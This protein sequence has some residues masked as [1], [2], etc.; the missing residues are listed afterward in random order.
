MGYELVGKAWDVP[1][2]REYVQE[3]PRLGWCK[4]IC[5]HHTA[6]PALSHRPNGWRLQHM[7]NLKDYYQNHLG[8]SAGPHLFTDED[9]VFGMSSLYRPGV[10]AKSFNRDS[11]GIEVLGNY[12]EE[13]PRSGRGLQCWETTAHVVR[14]LLQ[15]QG[16]AL[17]PDTVRFHRDDPRTSKTCPG[18]LVD[19]DWFFGLIG[20]QEDRPSDTAPIVGA[21]NGSQEELRVDLL[22]A[23]DNIARALRRTE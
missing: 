9:Q 23:R 20:A 18:E 2:F 11:I 6:M 1:A 12:D 16:L 10:H 4:A 13:D 8:W 22:A 15:H 14:I 3:L 5:V 19:R 7:R 17:M 21:G